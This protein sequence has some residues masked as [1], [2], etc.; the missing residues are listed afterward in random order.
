MIRIRPAEVDDGPVLQQIER[1]AGEQFREIGMPEIAE[2]DPPPLATLEGYAVAG[3]SWVAVDD[4]GEL[5]GYV[6]V[7]EVDGDAHVEQVSVLPDQQGRGVGR[8]LL[9]RV[10]DW[11]LQHGHGA[12]SL[13]TFTDVPWNRP[14]YEHI[15]FRVLSE[16]ELGPELRALREAEAAHGL[17]PATRVCMRLELS[18][19]GVRRSA[20]LLR[21]DPR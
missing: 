1:R 9:G 21:D 15:G 3:R 2:D 13:T 4:D 7:D 12:I 20:S 19:R 5:V 18:E 14:L 17:D 6:L 10:S 16:A 8:A 11:A